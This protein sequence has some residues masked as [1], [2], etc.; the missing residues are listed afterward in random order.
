MRRDYWLIAGLALLFFFLGLGEVHLFDWD[1]INFAECAREMLLTG[2]YLRPQ[3]DFEPFWE[4]PPLFIW[5]QALSMRLVGVNEYAARL[6]NAV[7]GLA[8]LLLVYQIGR[9]VYDRTFAWVWVLAWLGSFLPHLYFV[10]GIIDPW[11]NLFIFLGLYGFIEFRWLFFTQRTVVNFW[12]KYRWLLVGGGLVGMAIL[13]KG[14]VAYLVAALTLFVYYA[15][16][17]FQNKGFLRHTL[18]FS[19][20]AAVV[21]LLWFGLEIALHGTWFVREFIIY[22]IRLFATPDAGHVGFWGYH[23]VVLLLGCFPASVLAMPNLWGDR[24][25]EDE[26]MESNTLSSCKRSDFTTWM[27]ILFWV[28]LV[29]FSI[30]RTKIVHYSSLCYFPLT[31]LAAVTVWRAMWWSVRPRITVWLWPV[32]AILMSAM[33]LLLPWVGQHI[34]LLH[35]LFKN[36]LFAQQNLRAAVEWTWWHWI[37]GLVLLSSALLGWWY[38]QHDRAWN[39]AQ[40]TFGGGALFMASALALFSGNIEAYSQRAAIEFYEQCAE[41]DCYVRPVGFKSYAHLFYA[42]KQ[43]IS[44]P[45]RDE[46]EVLAHGHPDKKV[47]FVARCHRLEELPQLPHC[48]ELYRKNGFVFY[49]RFK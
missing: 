3:I 47:Y 36:D 19:G 43:P 35:P 10:S 32:L 14:P 5:L 1:E 39:A 11:F 22:Q 44:D 20:A 27:Q 17:R 4:K 49:E 26:V 30:V 7:C 45:T 29:L 16:Y 24:Q 12:K 33:L 2:D 46:Y 25:P 15:R 40:V 6:P 13:T 48:K 41:E 9:R 8:T 31:Y 37:P 28:V 21:T 38:W 18:L 23:V 42:Q 34:D